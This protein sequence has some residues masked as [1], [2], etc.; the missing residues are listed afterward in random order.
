MARNEVVAARQAAWPL[1]NPW[2]PLLAGL[3]ASAAALLWAS[4]A[5][6]SFVPGRV[7]LLLAGLIAAGTGVAVRFRTAAWD[8]ES[9]CY[10][11]GAIGLAAFAAVLSTGALDEAWDSPR[12]LLRAVTAVALVGAG[13]VCLSRLWRRL[14]VSLIVLFHFGGILCAVTSVPPPGGPAPWIT[15][16]LWAHVYRPYLDFLYLNNAYHFYSPEP[17]PPSLLWFYLEYEDGSTRQVKI[18]NREDFP[19]R[20]SYQRR[21]ALTESTA[22]AMENGVANGARN[23]GEAASGF[24]KPMDPRHLAIPSK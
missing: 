17:G 10:T 19:T 20:L 13:L 22:Q 15:G 3:G 1:Q 8:L 5:P 6:E 14:A 18:P 16:T 24:F 4:V 9:R 23:L 21:L 2:P 7:I 12:M 11:A